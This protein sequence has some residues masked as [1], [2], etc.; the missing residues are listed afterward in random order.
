MVRGLTLQLFLVEAGKPLEVWS[1]LR[2]PQLFLLLS[3]QDVFEEQSG[4]VG[5]R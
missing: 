5:S 3:G 4:T 2:L 1:Q